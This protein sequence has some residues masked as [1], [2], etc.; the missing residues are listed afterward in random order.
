MPCNNSQESTRITHDLVMGELLQKADN[1]SRVVLSGYK[2]EATHISNVNVLSSATFSTVALSK[3]ADFLVVKVLDD[4]GSKILNNKKEVA[5]RIILKIK[6]YF[7]T[8]CA[9]C[10]DKYHVNF[11]DTPLLTCHS[12]FKGSHDCEKVKEKL[13]ALKTLDFVIG[14]VWL[15]RDCL[16]RNDAAKTYRPKN[17]V[18]NPPPSSTISPTLN[19]HT[20]QLQNEVDETDNDKSSESD[21]LTQQDDN[22]VPPNKRKDVCNKYRHGNCPHGMSGRKEFEGKSACIKQHPHRC[23]RYSKYG[24]DS[25]K[26]CT[27]GKECKYFHPLICRSSAKKHECLRENCTHIHLRFTKRKKERNSSSEPKEKK[28]RQP[29]I[30]STDSQ[31]KRYSKVNTMEEQVFRKALQCLKEEFRK[32]LKELKDTLTYP[33]PVHF[34]AQWPGMY[35]PQVSQAPVNQPHVQYMAPMRFPMPPLNKTTP[36]STC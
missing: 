24:N 33:S 6:S 9:E 26:G 2:C 12:C 5:D 1:V 31:N 25:K 20:I 36:Q 16:P 3:C 8:V 21:T 35:V 19:D 28:A 34:P 13:D 22:F 7:T 30:G 11:G 23:Y 4:D 18:S 14:M 10:E 29:K 32:D 17:K 27:K 15:C